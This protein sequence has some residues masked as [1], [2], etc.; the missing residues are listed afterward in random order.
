MLFG[1]PPFQTKDVKTIYQNI[2]ELKYSFPDDT[3]V[4]PLAMDLIRSILTSDPKA[5][6]SLDDILAD[7]WFVEGTFPDR[8][9]SVAHDSHPD[10]SHITLDQSRANFAKAKRDCA[11]G[12]NLPLAVPHPVPGNSAP[13]NSAQARQAMAPAIA[14]QEREFKAAVKPDSPI[15]ALLSSARKP[16][17]VAP[18]LP[19]MPRGE[20]SLLRKFQ[21]QTQNHTA[22]SPLRKER[23]RA[24]P[25]KETRQPY[26]ME[27]L[28]E[29]EDIE[30]FEDVQ[31]DKAS[32]PPVKAKP[33][34]PMSPAAEHRKN[35][36]PGESVHWTAA[37][38]NAHASRAGRSS[39]K[40]TKSSELYDTVLGHIMGAMQ[41]L[42]AA[43]P[44][45]HPGS[46]TPCRLPETLAAN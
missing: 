8:I 7:P 38:G 29:E 23:A 18:S 3:T 16:P 40:V 35:L 22:K 25:A 31:M 19:T 37:H 6:P 43:Q 34:L 46:L 44:Y 45:Q 42:D 11:I 10:F 39:K 9:P 21:S 33:N 30:E 28:G 15:A 1:R 12:Q 36:R 27:A 20:P 17:V 2:K 26:K 13:T 24:R 4:S 32:D 41:S 5:R 14:Q